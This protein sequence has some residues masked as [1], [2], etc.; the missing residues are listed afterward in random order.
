MWLLASQ[1][2]RTDIFVTYS[3]TSS[4]NDALERCCPGCGLERSILFYVYEYFVCMCVG[5]P[6]ACPYKPE[7]R[8]RSPESGVVSTVWVLETETPNG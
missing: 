7:G 1:Y 2:L 4:H 3:K 5:A 6:P 8:I